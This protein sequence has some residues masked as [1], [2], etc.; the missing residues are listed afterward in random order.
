MVISKED[1][2]EKLAKALNKLMSKDPFLLKNDISERAI[3]HRLAIYIENEFITGELKE[4]NTS[5]IVS[6][7]ALAKTLNTERT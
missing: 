5:S 6:I 4:K 7:M 3:S 2:E 1:I